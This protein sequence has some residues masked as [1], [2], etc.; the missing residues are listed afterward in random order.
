MT[1]DQVLEQLK[2]PM[3]VYESA[4]WSPHHGGQ[5]VLFKHMRTPEVVPIPDG[6]TDADGYD[7][8]REFNT[9][10]TTLRRLKEVR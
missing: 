9:F 7:L 4:W 2:E 5:L 1:L 10:L 3:S 6:L 8:A